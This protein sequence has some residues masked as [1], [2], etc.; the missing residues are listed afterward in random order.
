MTTGFTVLFTIMVGAWP[1]GAWAAAGLTD[2]ATTA[3][4]PDSTNSRR[5]TRFAMR[6]SSVDETRRLYSGSAAVTTR[7]AGSAVDGGRHA[8]VRWHLLDVPTERFPDA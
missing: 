5:F 3:A 2:A 8:P 1:P 6:C 7:R 4:A